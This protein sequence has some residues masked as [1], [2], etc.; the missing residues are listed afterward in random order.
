MVDDPS[1][2]ADVA[3]IGAGIG[4]LTAAALLAKSGLKVCVLEMDARPGG[5]LA[6]FR[7][8]PF[9]FDT[10]IH[11]LNQCGPKGIVTTIFEHVDEGCPHAPSLTHIRRFRGESHDYLLTSN[12]DELRDR[13]VHETP[14]EGD[15]ITRFFESGEKLGTSFREL[16][17]LMRTRESMGAFEKARTGLRMGRTAFP[18][19]RWARFSAEKAFQKVFQSPSLRRIFCTDQRLISCLAPIA[20][21]Y[22]HDYQAPPAGGSQAYPKF[23]VEGIKRRGGTVSFRSR[24]EEIVIENGAVAGLRYVKGRRN[25]QPGSVKCKYVLAACDLS[26][27]Y[28]KMLPAGSV[29]AGVLDKLRKAEIYD[30]TVTLSM[31]LKVPPQELGFGEEL[32][33]LTR[34]NIA[35]EAHNDGNP[36]TSAISVLAPSLRDP[37]MA[38]AGKGTLTFST[39]AN[40]RYG[41]RWKTGPDDERG[42]A[43]KS[44]KRAY[45]DVLIERVQATLA[46]GLREQIE[47]LEIATPVTHLRYTG[48]RDG[49]IM[50][51]KPTRGNIHNGV[52]GYRTPIKNLLLASHWAEYG[53]GVP[54]AVRAGANSALLVLEEQNKVEFERL[55]AVLDGETL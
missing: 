24:V 47:L 42:D 30:S 54:I 26:T 6:G 14:Q 39:T 17:F 10:A 52:A 38:P 8:G 48:N 41:D 16:S 31:G 34:D 36:H 35:I 50:A 27:L 25:P 32:T 9:I 18:M 45:A 13:L 2:E 51:A 21:A 29:P 49:S 53:G 4:G 15:A 46:P 44:F 37:T 12:P 19:M 5:Y 40:I 33:F 20:W 22:D 7:R 11:W 1:S 3:I 55:R 23:L 43:Y 28:E